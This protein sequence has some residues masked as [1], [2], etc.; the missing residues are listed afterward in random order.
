MEKSLLRISRECG[1]DAFCDVKLLSRIAP[2]CMAV[3]SSAG[4]SLCDL[5]GGHS[6]IHR[7]KPVLLDRA[8]PTLERPAV[9]PGGGFQRVLVRIASKCRDFY[10]HVLIAQ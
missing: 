8:A 4:F 5:S 3:L 10:E 2:R 1:K 9:I 6:T 7:L